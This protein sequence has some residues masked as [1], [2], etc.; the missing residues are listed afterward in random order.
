MF[1]P[2]EPKFQKETQASFGMNFLP[3][4]FRHLAIFNDALLVHFSSLLVILLRFF[5]AILLSS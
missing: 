3:C 2:N 1:V 4:A 5:A